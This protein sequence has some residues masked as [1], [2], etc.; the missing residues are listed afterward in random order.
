[1]SKKV[2][3]RIKAKFGDRI[4]ATSSALGDDEAIV[5]PKDWL[6]VARFLRDDPECRMDHFIDLT[7]VDYPLREP[8]LPRFDV[9][10]LLRSMQYRHRVRLKTRVGEGQSVPSVTSLWPGANWAERECWDM[11]G[12]VFEGH[13][14][15]RRILLYEEFVGHPLRKDYPIGKAQP[16]VPYRRVEGIDKLPPF[17]PDEGQPWSRIDW[18]ERLRGRDFQVSPAIGLQQGQRPALSRGPEYTDLDDK[19]VTQAQD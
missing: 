18:Q 14:D 5:D 10:L 15:L 12:V 8:E 2:L 1:M 3:D 17:G 9:L 6:E 13:P 16:L 4:L 11:F 19:A 7:A